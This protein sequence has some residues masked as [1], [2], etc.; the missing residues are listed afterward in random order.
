[1][2]A[3]T[4]SWFDY[5]F[6]DASFHEELSGRNAW[7]VM[8]TAMSG[9]GDAR[10]HYH[11]VHE[12][13]HAILS[14]SPVYLAMR[15]L[16]LDSILIFGSLENCERDG[17]PAIDLSLADPSLIER[18]VSRYLASE[19]LQAYYAPLFEGLACFAELNLTI[20]EKT[21]P[22]MRPLSELLLLM[23]QATER[24]N[25]NVAS[26]SPAASAVERLA[27]KKEILRNPDHRLATRLSILNEPIQDELV[28]GGYCIGYNWVNATYS[29]Y[30][31]Y[32]DPEE[33]IYMLMDLFLFDLDVYE[34]AM[35]VETGE[36]ADRLHAFLRERIFDLISFKITMNDVVD[37]RPDMPT[38]YPFPRAWPGGVLSSMRQSARDLTAFGD[39]LMGEIQ[40]IVSEAEESPYVNKRPVILTVLA[41]P[42]VSIAG[43]PAASVAPAGEGSQVT[44]TA[45]GKAEHAD[46]AAFSWLEGPVSC[47][48][49]HYGLL[50]DLMDIREVVSAFTPETVTEVFSSVGD[51]QSDM[52]DPMVHDPSRRIFRSLLAE[53]TADMETFVNTV[54]ERRGMVPLAR[55]RPALA[56]SRNDTWYGCLPA[57]S[58]LAIFHERYTE[59]RAVSSVRDIER[60]SEPYV[61][62]RFFRKAFGRLDFGLLASLANKLTGESARSDYGITD[63]ELAAA[64]EFHRLTGHDFVQVDRSKGLA[65]PIL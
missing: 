17:R 12:F 25:L 45:D 24:P 28:S 29:E 31:E 34:M 14:A 22:T 51:D 56:R 18:G 16:R 20:S 27:R 35:S 33:Y 54:L 13:T 47:S 2:T 61:V 60:G 30:Q 44:W 42:F 3:R 4:R 52:S 37:R 21:H 10:L 57:G 19:I 23:A 38:V 62:P 1:M 8:S 65:W 39:H 43:A 26:L 55:F 6:F 49:I 5:F 40:R 50:I 15:L 46:L 36:E 32:Y 53:V 59:D 7:D 11:I 48:H 41:S 64:H 9:V 58:L 63:A